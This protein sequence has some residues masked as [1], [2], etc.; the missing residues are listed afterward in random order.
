[1]FQIIRMADLITQWHELFVS[2]VS[3]IWVKVKKSHL[4]WIINVNWVNSIEKH[5]FIKSIRDS[6][7]E[8]AFSKECSVERMFNR[9]NVQQR[10]CS[11]KRML[12][13][14]DAEQR[15]STIWWLNEV[16]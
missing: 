4:L 16:H 12:S 6:N 14:E 1:M 10:E 9:E 13:K 3:I 8:L 15:E 7:S 2:L 5:F 11:A